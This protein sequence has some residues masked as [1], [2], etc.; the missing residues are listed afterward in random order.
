[1]KQSSLFFLAIFL[2]TYSGIASGNQQILN[3][4]SASDAGVELPS[5]VKSPYFDEQ[6]LAYTYDPG[7]RVEINAPSVS[8]FDATLPTALVFYGL[9]DGV[10]TDWTIGK[11][12]ENGE[13]QHYKTQ[14]IGAQTRF[15]RAQ[16]PGCNLVTIYMETSQKNWNTWRTGTTNGNSIIK[17]CTESILVLFEDYNPYVVL[18]GHGGGG[19]HTFGFIEAA[20]DIPSY[21]KRISFIDSNYNWDNDRHGEKLVRWLKAS[22]DNCLSV[23]CYDDGAAKVDGQPIIA[24]NE[25]TCYRSLIMQQYLKQNL[26]EYTWTETDRD[27]VGTELITC[28]A[29]DNRIQF[30]LKTNVFGSVFHDE[31]VEKNGYIQAL[32]SSTDKEDVNYSFW[33]ARAYDSYIQDVRV[34]PHILRIPPRPKNA[35]GGAAFMSNINSM[36]LANRENAIYKEIASGNIPNSF[37]KINRITKTIKDTDNKNCV[38]E[39]EVLPDFLA[40]GSDTDFCRIPMLPATA[41]KIATLFGATLPTSKISDLAWEFATVKLSPQTMNPDASMTTV[42]VFIAHN[43]LV[44]SA[45]VALGKP[46]SAPIAGHKKDIIITNRIATD[47]TKV[48]IYGWHYTSGTPIQSISGAHNSEYVDYSHGVRMVNQEM[49]VDGQLTKVRDVLRDSKKHVLLSAENGTMTRT[50]YSVSQGDLP[51]AVKSFAVIP[52]SATSVKLLL[53]TTSG[54]NYRVF[55]GTS[56]NSL[57][58]SYI[59]NSSNPVIGGL[60]EDIVYYF[61]VEA[62]NDSGSASMSKKLAV[63]P[64]DKNNF[65]LLVEGF[66]RI[67]SGNSGAFVKQ[68]AEALAAL[69][70]PIASAS[71][72]AIIAGLVNLD[73]YPFVDWILGEESTADRTFDLNEQAKVKSYLEAGGFLYVSAAE[74]GWDI[75]RT[76][77]VNAAVK[78]T[79]D[80]LKFTFVA[81]NPG[82]GKA[83]SHKAELL[84]D[85]GFG[86]EEFSFNFAD[87]TATAVEYPDVIAPVGGSVG[88][89]RYVLDSGGST[90]VNYAGVAYAGN[91]G[92]SSIPGKVIVMGIPFESIVPVAKRNELMQ[93]ILNFENT[94]TGI[95]TV[96]TDTKVYNTPNGIRIDIDAP[97]SVAVYT[98]S[99]QL[100]IETKIDRNTEYALD[101]GIYIV[102]VNDML[103]KIVK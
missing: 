66:N 89:L 32:L 40:I 6:V 19:S 94:E 48:Y 85:T 41:Q 79:T 64:T 56:I 42:P 15:I 93:M 26:S 33:G 1:M 95:S 37:R 84:P 96:L 51:V 13:N 63:T 100:L 14:H 25:G 92:N 78:F 39:L 52:E 44:E 38:V 98:V 4:L 5:F 74:I 31:L 72:D 2:S 36:S 70:K 27:L 49:T 28:S 77:S 60:T 3:L 43:T 62:F 73:D 9:P 46:L 86:S 22:D 18:V 90:N 11:E 35:I 65:A 20:S 68:H 45:R 67:V 99:G 59:Y 81:D 58:N 75:A 34:Y 50:E 87:G 53:T 103:T 12:I 83:Q 16:E 102:R 101:R 69:D 82:T 24:P 8:K 55:Y 23:I 10:S 71:N 76:A 97:A 7:I 91:F 61:A 88:F 57:T 80:Y 47:N 17:E 21:V 54:I 29:N 30:L